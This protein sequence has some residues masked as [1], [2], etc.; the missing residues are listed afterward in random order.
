MY[1]YEETAGEKG[2]VKTHGKSITID[3]KGL[4][5]HNREQARAARGPGRFSGPMEYNAKRTTSSRK[6]MRGEGS[7]I[8]DL[9]KILRKPKHF[10]GDIFSCR[11][12]CEIVDSS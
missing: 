9:C 7:H 4:R 2:L 5:K 12:S 1:K 6:R 3:M 10:C 8:L 11:L